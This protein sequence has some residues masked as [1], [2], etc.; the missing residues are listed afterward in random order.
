LKKLLQ[1]KAAMAYVRRRSN[2]TLL[3]ALDS[4][5]LHGDV[6]H[7]REMLRS[8]GKLIQSKRLRCGLYG[9][10]LCGPR[11]RR[12]AKRDMLKRL[13]ARFHGLPKAQDSTF[14][15]INGP[16]TDP[17]EAQA[18]ARNFH[19]RLSY[20]HKK[21]LPDTSWLGML[22][23]DLMGKVH[24]HGLIVHKGHSKAEIVEMLRTWFTDEGQVMASDW[25]EGNSHTQNVINVLDYSLRAERH[26]RLY[27]GNWTRVLRVQS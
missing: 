27:T 8:C 5:D 13:A 16:Y 26:T 10:A 17:D 20:A 2:S 3:A 23:I 14:F 24:F 21:L 19:R 25:L 15:S 12:D 7:V 1:E 11:F 4:T 18:A 22:D 6:D 9:C